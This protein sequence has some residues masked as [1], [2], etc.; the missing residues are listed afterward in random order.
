MSILKTRRLRFSIMWKMFLAALVIVLIA[1]IYVVA[2]L[3]P[4]MRKSLMRE[5]EI[6]TQEEV[7][8][9][10]GMLQFCYSL[11]STGL[12]TRTE[13][14]TYALAALSG[15]RYGENQEG[16]FWVNDYRP[17]MLMEPF[18]PDLVNANVSNVKDEQG[19]YI[20]QDMVSLCQSQGQGFY[21]YY[22]Q[23]KDQEG[24][25]VPKL[26][27]VKTFEP[28]GWMVGTG[29]YTQ[30]VVQAMDRQRNFLGIA[31]GIATLVGIFIFWVLTRLV[32]GRPIS[33][34]VKTSKALARGDVEQQVR[35]K[36]NDEIGEL[37]A[38][39]SGVIDYMREMAGATKRLADGDL[40]VEVKAK[41]DG[42]IL[43]NAFAQLVARQRELIGKMKATASSVSEASK[44]LTKASE[45]TAQATQ[46][47]AGTI[48]QVAKS[49]SQQSASL[50]QTSKGM[51]QLSKAIEQISEGAQQQSQGV[52]E[53]T[54]IV[55][56]VSAA[57]V[58]VSGNAKAGAEA[59]GSTSVSAA[60]GAR[61]TH[62]TVEGMRRI[63]KAMDA[64]SSKVTDLGERS[65]EIG[66]I[67]ATIDD[68]AAQTNLL[69]LN[70]AIEAARAGEQ[71]RGFAVV[72]D[73]VRK[74]A[75]RS[76]VATKEIATIVSGIQ[77]RVREAVSA[78]QQ[79]GKE[80]ELGYKLAADA[81]GALDNILE[82]SE[83]VGKQVEQI[84]Q[85]AHQLSNLSSGM[86]EAIDQINRIVEQNAAAT[87]E[88][89]ASSETVS[90]SVEASAGM[91]EEYNT[92][93]QEVSASVE[94]MSA[95]AE[96][97]LAAAQ[98]LAEM[99]EE[100]ERAIAVFKMEE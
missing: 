7:E 38:A 36:S 15:L 46:Q 81:G 87:E 37:A 62:E 56:K 85:A 78:M 4:E 22:W 23:Y 48:Q 11:E 26:S 74:L 45:Q 67:V 57:I 21:N 89:T 20:F 100:M 72:A 91:A 80:V 71:G 83:K 58:G 63:K 10:Y 54:G 52:E 88:M 6:K 99:S 27:Y 96:E 5:K 61:M 70:A 25:V 29:I 86:V 2:Y 97:A 47:I 92:A 73:E 16:Y 9:A 43:A 76:S 95:Q 13:A 3:L 35:V 14:Q 93:S 94:E 77:A 55:K 28:W 53:A 84:S 24:H 18:R 40:A 60:D 75:E 90:K 31:Y 50:Q 64:A 59:W 98:S 65:E 33:S 82:R 66:R 49:A 69:A 30:D 8:V 42:D 17:V 68:I 39:Y 79:G 12:V 32:I 51:E 44:Q 34:L 19:S 1:D 41:S